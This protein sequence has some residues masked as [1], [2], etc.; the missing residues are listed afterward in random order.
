MSQTSDDLKK[1][2]RPVVVEDFIS[3]PSS[4][5]MLQGPP[6]Q[7]DTGDISLVYIHLILAKRPRSYP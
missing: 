5:E 6:S 4:S 2:Y 3:K 7:I 1:S